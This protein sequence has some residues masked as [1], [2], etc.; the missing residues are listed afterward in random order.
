MPWPR[1]SFIFNNPRRALASLARARPATRAL[2]YFLRVAALTLMLPFMQTNQ[3]PAQANRIEI[4]RGVAAWYWRAYD[5]QNNLLA[6][7]VAA[8]KKSARQAVAARYGQ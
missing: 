5:A 1:A 8:T 7:G 6:V 4:A 2:K 3:A